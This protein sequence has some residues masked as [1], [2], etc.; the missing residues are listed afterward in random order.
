IVKLYTNIKRKIRKRIFIHKI[1]KL[2]DIKVEIYLST[3]PPRWIVDN[4]LINGWWKTQIVDKWISHPQSQ[5][6]QQ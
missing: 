3:Y 1:A 2:L 4:L 5:S 6:Y